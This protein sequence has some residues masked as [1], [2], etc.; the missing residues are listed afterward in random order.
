MIR[1]DL[2]LLYLEILDKRDNFASRKKFH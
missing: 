1:V 2:L